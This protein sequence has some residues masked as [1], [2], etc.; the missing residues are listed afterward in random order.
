M[1]SVEIFAC[2]LHLKFVRGVLLHLYLLVNFI[3]CWKVGI[4]VDRYWEIMRLD[5][6]CWEI[7]FK[8][9]FNNTYSSP[10]L[11]VVHHWDSSF[12]MHFTFSLVYLLLLFLTKFIILHIFEVFKSYSNK[13][14]WILKLILVSCCM[15]HFVVLF[16]CYML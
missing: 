12:N 1:G 3:L 14:I 10:S 13:K 11:G 16:S 4:E 15:L 9:L 7:F 5:N 6:L 8:K 2:D